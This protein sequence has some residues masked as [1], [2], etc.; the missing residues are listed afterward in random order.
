ME[1]EMSSIAHCEGCREMKAKKQGSQFC[2][3]HRKSLD[4]SRKVI[5]RIFRNVKIEI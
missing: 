1:R 3:A 5:D 2:E 4:E